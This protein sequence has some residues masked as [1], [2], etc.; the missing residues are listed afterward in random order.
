MRSDTECIYEY[1]PNNNCIQEIIIEGNSEI[2]Y[3]HKYDENHRCI[4]TT[5]IK[6]NG[7]S[8]DTTFEYDK[9]N[10]CIK[11]YT[12]SGTI[13]YTYELVGYKEDNLINKYAYIDSVTSFDGYIPPDDLILATI[14]EK[15]GFDKND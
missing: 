3:I 12:N 8:G 7:E 14:A 10:N 1:S 15:K 4:K 5:T 13:N 6:D 9:Y 2:K 11:K